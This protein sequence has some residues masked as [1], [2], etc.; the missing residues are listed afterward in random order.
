M[1]SALQIGR[2]TK[3]NDTAFLYLSRQGAI[4]TDLAVRMTIWNRTGVHTE[5]HFRLVWDIERLHSKF[6][7]RAEFRCGGV[8]VPTSSFGG[9]LRAR[10]F[11]VQQQGLQF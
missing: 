4:A 11:G 5:R 9:R 3:R 1:L 7:L 8:A 6:G 10:T 2:I